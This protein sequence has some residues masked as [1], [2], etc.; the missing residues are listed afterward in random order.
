MYT[1]IYSQFPQL[2]PQAVPVPISTRNFYFPPGFGIL[3]HFAPIGTV[4]EVTNCFFI[5]FL[6]IVYN[7]SKNAGAKLLLHFL[8]LL[9]QNGFGRV[10]I[11]AHVSYIAR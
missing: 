7:R 1:I 4:P 2:F 9:A 6:C 3:K 10:G 5:H 8:N 11:Q